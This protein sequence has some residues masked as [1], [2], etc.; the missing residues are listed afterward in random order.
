MTRV[1]FKE[2]TARADAIETVLFDDDYEGFWKDYNEI[3]NVIAYSIDG[4]SSK[5][6]ILIF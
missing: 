5:S 2:A 3:T 6:N 4:I 1:S